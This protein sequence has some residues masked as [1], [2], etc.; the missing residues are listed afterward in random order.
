[1]IAFLLALSALPQQTE[2]MK[3]RP[4]TEADAVAEFEATCVSNFHNVEGLKRAAAAS[5]RGYAFEDSPTPYGWRNWTSPFGTVH[6]YEGGEQSSRFVPECNLTSFTRAPVNRRLLYAAVEAMA[7]RQAQ[8]GLAESDQSGH[9]A[10]SWFG[11]N[12]SP[13]MVVAVLDRKTPNQITLSLKPM[14]VTR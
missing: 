3:V 12:K 4:S 1:M 9:R 13:A 2:T 14:A 10:W 6:Y 7:M 8:S 5:R 11:A